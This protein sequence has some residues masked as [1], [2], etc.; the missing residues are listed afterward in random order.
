MG[1]GEL[2]LRAE[3]G[4]KAYFVDSNYA[5]ACLGGFGGCDG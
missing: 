5:S 2:R 4:G 1:R 3:V